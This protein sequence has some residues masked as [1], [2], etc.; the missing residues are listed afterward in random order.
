MSR[1]LPGEGGIK[2]PIL[3]SICKRINEM[4]GKHRATTLEV[5]HKAGVC[6]CVSGRKCESRTGAAA[7]HSKSDSAGS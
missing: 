4:G 2:N 3:G 7:F 1:L 6:V 5:G